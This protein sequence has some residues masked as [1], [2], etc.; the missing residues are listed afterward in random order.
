MGTLTPEEE[1]M[2]LLTEPTEGISP[3]D[4][5]DFGPI[6]AQKVALI[7]D[8][9]AIAKLILEKV[10]GHIPD[11]ITDAQFTLHDQTTQVGKDN[12]KK[13]ISA[14]NTW[15]TKETSIPESM[16]SSI[17]KYAPIAPDAE[18]AEPVDYSKY[19]P[20]LYPPMAKHTMSYVKGKYVYINPNVPP[21]DH[22]FAIKAAVD[23]HLKNIKKLPP[24]QPIIGP[25]DTDFDVE[26]YMDD[27]QNFQGIPNVHASPHVFEKFD[28]SRINSGEGTQNEG[29]GLYTSGEPE[30]G[31]HYKNQFNQNVADKFHLT[32]QNAYTVLKLEKGDIDKALK[33]VARPDY[34]A[35]D[36]VPTHDVD[37]ILRR[38]KAKGVPPLAPR[39]VV[40]FQVDPQDLIDGRLAFER[41]P[42]HVQKR[43]LDAWGHLGLSTNRLKL[44]TTMLRHNKDVAPK[45]TS[46]APH[47]KTVSPKQLSI[48]YAEQGIPGLMYKDPDYLHQWPNSKPNYVGY[49]DKFYKILK[50]YSLAGLM[51][52]AGLEA[53]NNLS[54][55][56]EA[57][58]V[59]DGKPNNKGQ[60]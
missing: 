23:E 45:H 57:S 17:K 27:P 13:I 9:Q 38:W 29:W 16:V 7:S 43:I 20:H 56:A 50:K 8:T 26:A 47:L 25:H 46:V 3:Q 55:E 31:N 30:V 24:K 33:F 11:A 21:K 22:D 52:G 5:V 49:T 19:I 60:K 36:E 6:A 15:N 54:D 32:E 35:F 4:F 34:R 28:I 59:K 14:L 37:T 51:S 42:K 12:V 2:H 40:D 53:L 10:K 58:T 18:P 39:Y 1:Q 48:A 44:D 41:Q